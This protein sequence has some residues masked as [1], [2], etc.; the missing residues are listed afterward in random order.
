M[1]AVVE[2]ELTNTYWGT[3]ED[4][5]EVAEL[6]R[7]GKITPK[8]TKYPMEKALDAYQDSVDGKVSDR[9]V[10]TPHA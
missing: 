6:F 9:T 10:V 2:V 1:R 5:H 3:I 4:L 8:V 7:A